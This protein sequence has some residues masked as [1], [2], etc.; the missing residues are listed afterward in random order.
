MSFRVWQSPKS[1]KANIAMWFGLER[2]A[3]SRP[4]L[5]LRTTSKSI[6]FQLRA[7]ADAARS[8]GLSRHSRSS[9][10]SCR[11]CARYITAD[12]RRFLVWVVSLRG[13]AELRLGSRVSHFS[14]MNKT[15]WPARPIGYS[16]DSHGGF[17]RDSPGAFRQAR[18]RRMWAIPCVGQ[19]P[20]SQSIRRE[21]AS[22]IRS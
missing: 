5:S 16:L 18:G 2:G 21:S 19:S 14:S 9:S 3:A 7:C 10:R 12:P 20:N 22:S 1:C 6:G 15:R 11:H 13:P 17:S 8:R 4:A